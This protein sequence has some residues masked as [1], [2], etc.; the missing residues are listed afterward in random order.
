MRYLIGLLVLAG[1]KQG[2]DPVK[3]DD[4][5]VDT[6]NVGLDDLDGDGFSSDSGDCDDEDPAVNPAAE[7]ACD[8]VDQNCD[9]QID[10]G[11][12]RTL[13]QDLDGDGYGDPATA[14]TSCQEQ[15]GFVADGTDCDDQAATIYPGAPESCTDLL[16]LNCDGFPG[17]TDTDGDGVAACEDCNDGDASVSPNA[18]EV[19]DA[20]NID[21]DCDGLADDADSSVDPTGFTSSYTD[22]DGDGYGDPATETLACD[23]SGVALGADCNDGD[24]AYN[25]GAL[26]VDCN[27]P[28]DY[29]CD[30][31]VGY[32]DA[33]GD[34]FAACEECDDSNAAVSPVGVEE[35][36]LVDDDCDGLIDEEGSTAGTWYLD[37]DGDGY[38]DA[39]SPTLSCGQPTGY[40]ADDG[41]CDDISASVNPGAIEVC[42]G[43][44]DDCDG[45]V[46]VGAI[47][48]GTWYVD[49]DGDGYGD[50]LAGDF[51]SP[52][53][54]TVA[55]DGDCDDADAA[56]NP[57]AVEADCTDPN[58]YN[59]DGTTGYV[60]QDADGVAACADCDDSNTSVYPGATEACNGI[61]DNCDGTIDEAGATGE[62]T[63]YLDGDGD[64]YGDPGI[65]LSS[66]TQPSSYTAN[67]DDCDDGRPDISPAATEFCNGYDDNCDGDID[68]DAVDRSTWYLDSDGDGYGASAT[69]LSCTQPSGYSALDGDCDDSD[70]AYNPGA[71]EA[72][73][74]DPNDYNCDGFS[75]YVNSDGDAFAACEDCDDTDAGVY[76]GATEVCDRVDNNCDGSVDESSAVDATLWY[77]D[78]D[79]DGFGDPATSQRACTQ[80]GGYVA[81]NTD[82]DDSASDISPAST[83]VCNGYDDNCDGVIDSDAVDRSTWYLDND[84]DGFGGSSTVL[85][86]TAP[87]NSTAASTDC[88]DTNAAVNPDA[89]E[90]CNNIDDNCDGSSD[91]TDAWW[92]S[93]WPYRVQVQVSAAS[94]DLAGAP[95]DVE[96]DFRDLLDQVEDSTLFSEDSL[97]V[98]LQ[99]CTLSQPELPSQFLDGWVGMREKVAYADPLGDEYGTVAFLYDEDGNY[100]SLETFAASS[101]VTFGIYF[102]GTQ[103][104]P[105]YSTG[106]SATSSRM[107]TGSSVADFSAAAGG[108]LSGLTVGASPSLENQSTS[109]CGNSFYGASWGIDPQDAAGTLT[110]VEDG[111]VVAA[112]EATGTRSDSQ[113]GYSYRYTYW[114]WAGRPELWS[115]VYQVTTRASTLSHTT[116]YTYGIRPWESRRDNISAGATFTTDSSLAWADVSNSSWG[117]AWGYVA[118]PTYLVSLS[119]YD[120]YLISSAN[121]YAAAGSGTN[122]ILPSGTAYMDNIVQLSLPHSGGYNGIADSFQALREGVGVVVGSTELP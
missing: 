3:E 66:C 56:Y 110:L 76:P 82:C 51:C 84:A 83:E 108:L 112:V 23:G 33:D 74:A 37:A 39:G 48:P 53:A 58:D 25:P 24:P 10:E 30:G 120:P 104:A 105:A 50:V 68:G 34:G 16:D 78:G 91:G 36:N 96:L 89:T 42:N 103:P 55:V 38:G 95:I 67:A 9:G 122:V 14:T 12:D 47:D 92:D 18:L 100:S 54:G 118:A 81:D 119:N 116:D 62:A 72:N 61:D 57:G 114:M 75:G 94:T 109:C 6:Q 45:S 98:V 27:D 113:S 52:P 11:L 28:N 115:K 86:C 4:P 31:S 65:A 21:E 49:N 117:V 26:E 19:C 40:V 99:D 1:C 64:G 59:C 5:P 7:E 79:T 85:S 17:A 80:P 8:G 69:T 35:C 2:G 101:T 29:N 32:T 46:D 22:V 88:D 90:V 63:W 77:L 41:D 111:P 97:R 106:L 43:M 70:T 71:S 102:G 93:A 87:A 121:D 107:A 60:D 73:C 44:D 20:A 13:F 15:Q